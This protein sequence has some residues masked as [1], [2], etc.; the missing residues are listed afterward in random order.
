MKNWV[1]YG[2]WSIGIYLLLII[3]LFPFDELGLI[4]ALLSPG[5]IFTEVLIPA[6]IGGG[7]TRNVQNMLQVPL[8]IIGWFAIG[9]IIGLIVNRLGT[10]SKKVFGYI[11]IAIGLG[12]IVSEFSLCKWNCANAICSVKTLEPGCILLFSII[13]LIL[14]CFGVF[15]IWKQNN[16]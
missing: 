10:T 1:K 2:L 14:L 11:F 12:A 16:K 6:I 5:I 4:I 15:I 8:S 7:L 13:G 3:V 9:S